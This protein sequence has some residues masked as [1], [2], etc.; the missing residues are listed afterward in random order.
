MSQKE[1][2]YISPKLI[3]YYKSY[4]WPGNIRQLLGH[5]NKKMKLSKGRKIELNSYDEDLFLHEDFRTQVGNSFLTLEQIKTE[6]VYKVYLY[7]DKN[8][9]KSAKVL[10]ISSNTVKT[11]I[12]HR[13]FGK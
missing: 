9:S 5:L 8:Y 2:K 13:L 11:L 6:Y 3:E 12:K 4:S 7:T 10:G 1:N